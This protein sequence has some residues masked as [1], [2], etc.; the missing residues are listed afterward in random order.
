MKNDFD[1]KDLQ[2]ILDFAPIV[3]EQGD[4]SFYLQIFK[5]SHGYIAQYSFTE[6][7]IHVDLQGLKFYKT[8][9]LFDTYRRADDL[10]EAMSGLLKLLFANKNEL[11]FIP[12]LHQFNT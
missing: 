2:E 3:V 12:R 4:K 11:K 5:S 8:N 10:Y 6:D 1:C 7:K 9:N